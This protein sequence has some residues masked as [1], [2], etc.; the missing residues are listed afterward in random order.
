MATSAPPEVESQRQSVGMGF[1]FEKGT[2]LVG[3]DLGWRE[4]TILRKKWGWK[5]NK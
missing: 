4:K 3:L 2:G 1:I 5:G